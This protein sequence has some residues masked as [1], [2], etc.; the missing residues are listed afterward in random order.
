[1]PIS[2][3]AACL[4]SLAVAP[5]ALAQAT[6]TSATESVTT[7]HQVKGGVV[8]AVDGNTVVVNEVDGL[9]EYTLPDGFKFDLDGQPVTVDQLKPGMK[10]GALITDKVVTRQV[11]TTRIASATVMQVAPGGIVV[12]DAQGNLKSYD[13]KDSAGNDI[14][15]VKDGKRI[16][17]RNVKKG[18]RLTGTV[19]T[20][21]PPQEIS[22]RSVVARATAPAPA[23]LA[24]AAA[25][26]HKLPKTAS[27]LPLFGLL[28]ALSAGAAMTLRRLRTRR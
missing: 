3:I 28:G 1:M 21:L 19:V 26:P 10:V 7:T 11:K 2:R 24:V 9:H 23:P 14:Y 22:Q 27:P 18:D 13:F 8:T 20:T 16:S 4:L 5:A 12:K 17:L 15:F 25:T 6:A